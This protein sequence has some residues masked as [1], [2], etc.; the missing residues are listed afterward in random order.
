MDQFAKTLKG[1]LLPQAHAQS[2]QSLPPANPSSQGD[3]T[4]GI[5]S[6]TGGNEKL[7]SFQTPSG[8]KYIAVH[9]DEPDGTKHTYFT[10][11]DP[12]WNSYQNKGKAEDDRMYGVMKEV[13]DH[14]K[15]TPFYRND[16]K[17][18]ISGKDVSGQYAQFPQSDNP[19]S[20]DNRW[21]KYNQ[22]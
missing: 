16:M 9:G 12:Q 8:I 17:D 14:Y 7:S 3:P 22:Q 13:A 5:P 10:I 6:A 21:S 18:N 15:T 4:Q 19:L 11:N 1:A 20:F 2:E